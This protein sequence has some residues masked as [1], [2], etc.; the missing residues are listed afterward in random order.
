[1]TLK[2]M[3]WA[4]WITAGALVVLAT[5][6]GGDDDTGG[7][8]GDGDG[9]SGIAVTLQE[10]A[11]TPDS[12]SV[13]A[14]EVTFDIENTGEETHEFVVL[15]TDIDPNE[16]PTADDGSVD[17]EGGEMEVVDE[18]EDIP[19]GDT[20]T[21]TV[22]LDAGAYAL[23]CNIVEEE[24]GGETESHYAQGMRIAFTVE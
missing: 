14:G 2:R 20:A 10:W 6:C 3:R 22:D 12:D 15:S 1:M 23:I 24:E 8:D 5:A 13:A 16:L 7:E 21:L 4:I 9:G 19:S 18:V 11:V 17:E